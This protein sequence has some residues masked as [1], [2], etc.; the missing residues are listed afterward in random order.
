M[1]TKLAQRRDK[2]ERRKG[3]NRTEA[4][5]KDEKKILDQ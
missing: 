2:Y 1:R 3:R 4:R 5:F